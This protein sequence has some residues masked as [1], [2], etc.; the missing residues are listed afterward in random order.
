MPGEAGGLS[1]SGRL[2]GV[3]LL[4]RGVGSDRIHGLVD[5]GR[6]PPSSRCVTKTLSR[7][8]ISDSFG[9]LFVVGRS[10][11]TPIYAA[12]PL[13]HIMSLSLGTIQDAVASISGAT[14]AESVE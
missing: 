9:L 6:L 2:P 1:E 11:E 4:F 13:G 12:V 5:L 7:S 8:G 14:E 3:A 10:F